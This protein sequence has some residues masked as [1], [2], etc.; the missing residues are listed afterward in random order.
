VSLRAGDPD[1]ATAEATRALE[2]ARSLQGGKRYS[3]LTGQ[4]LLLMARVQEARGDQATARQTAEEAVPNL[5]ETLGDEHP[6]ARR[7][8]AYAQKTAAEP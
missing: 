6:D 7:A 3:S 2:V 4:S 1:A 8:A 5:V